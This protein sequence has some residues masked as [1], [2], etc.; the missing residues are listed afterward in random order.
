ML[1][2]ALSAQQVLTLTSQPLRLLD[3]PAVVLLASVR[4]YDQRG[5]GVE[6]SFKG[7]KQGLGI[8]KRSKKRFAAKPMVMRLRA[9]A[10]NVIVW[11]RRWLASQAL[12]QYGMLRMVRDVFHMSGFLLT[13]ACGQV[14]Q[15]VLNQAAP[16]ASTLVHPLRKLLLC[17]QVAVTLGQSTM[18]L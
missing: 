6:T 12:Q 13:D 3:D 17:T 4:F 10:H 2:S 9:L 14:V 7:D 11:A 1:L 5:G 18:T 8:G 16:L 15:V